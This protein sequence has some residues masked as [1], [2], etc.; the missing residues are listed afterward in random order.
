[1]GQ[2]NPRIMS[3]DWDHFQQDRQSDRKVQYAQN[4]R[5]KNNRNDVLALR[6]LSK[7]YFSHICVVWKKKTQQ[8]FTGNQRIGGEI[9]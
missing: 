4:R 1:M 8:C 6:S 7:Q 3:Q 2:E 5:P 9:V